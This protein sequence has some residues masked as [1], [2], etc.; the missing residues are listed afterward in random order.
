M[1]MGWAASEEVAIDKSGLFGDKSVSICLLMFLDLEKYSMNVQT[2]IF[3]GLEQTN[4]CILQSVDSQTRT[5]LPTF[6]S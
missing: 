6:A 2:P 4:E 5:Y 3:L 1:R